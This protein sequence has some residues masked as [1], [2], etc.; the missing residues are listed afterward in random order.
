MGNT[1][2]IYYEKVN[3]DIKV[4]ILEEFKTYYSDKNIRE[5]NIFRRDYALCEI[6]LEKYRICFQYEPNL[7]DFICELN[8]PFVFSELN[9]NGYN[10]MFVYDLK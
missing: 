7:I 1:N 6:K 5:I 4:K 2:I 8:R 9:K 10:I 3:N